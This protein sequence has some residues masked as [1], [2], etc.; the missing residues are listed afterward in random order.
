[1]LAS[2]RPKGLGMTFSTGQGILGWTD[3]FEVWCASQPVGRYTDLHA[4]LRWL[5]QIA[6]H[7][8]PGAYAPGTTVGS[9][10]TDLRVLPDKRAPWP[11]AH[12]ALPMNAI[13]HLFPESDIDP[14]P[15]DKLLKNGV[16]AH[17]AGDHTIR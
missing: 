3:R 13:T 9:L 12:N 16:I 1:M 10:L 7:K 5:R 4:E 11:R 2:Y 15:A 8:V 6:H 17:I 14:T